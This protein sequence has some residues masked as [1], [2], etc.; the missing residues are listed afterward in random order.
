[1]C[2]EFTKEGMVVVKLIKCAQCLRNKALTNDQKK[3]L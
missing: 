1:M 3:F 2:E